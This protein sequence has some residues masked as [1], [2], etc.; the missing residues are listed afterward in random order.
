MKSK[1]VWQDGI[2]R[3]VLKSTVLAHFTMWAVR[4][5]PYLYPEKLAKGI[6]EMS[7]ALGMDVSYGG[8]F[9][10]TT[11]TGLGRIVRDSIELCVT[12]QSWNDAKDGSTEPYIF[13]T[14]YGEPHPDSDIIGL[15]ALA[16]NIA[17]SVWLELCYDDGWFE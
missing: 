12:V 10:E 16:R 14:R 7:I 2:K 8:G 6:E 13:T 3:V 11:C 1:L 15:D 4:Q 5:S 17:H 9:I